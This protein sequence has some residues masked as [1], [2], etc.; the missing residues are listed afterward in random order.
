MARMP[1]RRVA[2]H[3]R[4]FERVR[5]PPRSGL[6]APNSPAR[7]DLR[8]FARARHATA[9]PLAIRAGMAAPPSPHDETLLRHLDALRR[10][11]VRKSGDPDLIDDVL[12]ETALHALRRMPHLREPQ[13][14][15]GWLFRIMQRRLAQASRDRPP[16]LSLTTEPIVPPRVLPDP[17]TLQLIQRALRTLPARLRKPVR[18]H[19]LQGQPIRDVAATLRT[20]VNSVKAQLYRARCKLRATRDEESRG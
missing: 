13:R 12:Q 14:M 18:L 8:R 1:A 3:F 17:K 10:W 16:W 19:Y 9:P 4:G 7:I 15:R 2:R 6:D 11:C 5:A 20:S